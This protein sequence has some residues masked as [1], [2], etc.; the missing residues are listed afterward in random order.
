M[1]GYLSKKPKYF[2]WMIQE[3]FTG[4]GDV[5]HKLKGW[6]PYIEKLKLKDRQN[7]EGNHHLQVQRKINLNRHR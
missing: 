5:Q 3:N 7:L 4:K 1:V 6:K 2:L